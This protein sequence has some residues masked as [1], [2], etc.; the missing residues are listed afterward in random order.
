M[1]VLRV[2]SCGPLP[3]TIDINSANTTQTKQNKPHTDSH[4]HKVK[5]PSTN[6]RFVTSQQTWQIR[7]VKWEQRFFVFCWCSHCAVCGA[8]IGY[9]GCDFHLQGSQGSKAHYRLN[10][11]YVPNVD[12]AFHPPHKFAQPP[13]RE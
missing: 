11:P 6:C 8:H 2:T 4:S 10:L 1:P 7:T 3:S 5:W 12:S 9:N 13:M